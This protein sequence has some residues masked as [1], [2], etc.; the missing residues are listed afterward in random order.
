MHGDGAARRRHKL[1]MLLTPAAAACWT[2]APSPPVPC[3]A[4]SKGRWRCGAMACLPQETKRA[5]RR[6]PASS[7]SYMEQ[8][9]NASFTVCVCARAAV[10]CG[11]LR[12][13]SPSLPACCVWRPEANYGYVFIGQGKG[14][15]SE[16]IGLGGERGE[17]EGKQV[18]RRGREGVFWLTGSI[19]SCFC[20]N[21]SR[22]Q[23]L[24]PRP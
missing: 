15:G 4:N 24:T 18:D 16:G 5:R 1:L 21:P 6:S 14:K 23:P 11:S 19:G 20:V 12:S 9:A 2:S 7:T 8:S 10:C 3:D 17:G 22:R 13:R